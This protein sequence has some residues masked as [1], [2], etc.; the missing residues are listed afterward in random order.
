[1]LRS[2]SSD[3]KR[4]MPNVKLLIISDSRLCKH[5]FYSTK[6]VNEKQPVQEEIFLIINPTKYHA[7]DI[8][9]VM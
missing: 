1:M 7:N 6:H 5:M 8:Q 9:F 2:S 4:L 3:K